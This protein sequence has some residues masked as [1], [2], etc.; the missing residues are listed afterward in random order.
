MLYFTYEYSK[1]ILTGLFFGLIIFLICDITFFYYSFYYEQFRLLKSDA[2]YLNDEK[3]G[4]YDSLHPKGKLWQ[5]L[6]PKLK[7]MY[8]DL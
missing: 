5:L 8:S 6:M 3:Y 1:K 7:E 4:L 2:K